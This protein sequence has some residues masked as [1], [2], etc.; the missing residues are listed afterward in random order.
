VHDLAKPRQPLL[1]D[2]AINKGT[3]I[4]QDTSFANNSV[5]DT[6]DGTFNPFVNFDF[7][8]PTRP[9][10]PLSPKRAVPESITTPDYANDGRVM[11]VVR[12]LTAT[13]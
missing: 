11:G 13:L 6:T 1:D 3:G 10:Y 12:Q 8:G 7:T 2:P 5:S 9:V 4:L